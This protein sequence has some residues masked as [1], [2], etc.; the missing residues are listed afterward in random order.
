MNHVLLTVTTLVVILSAAAGCKAPYTMT[1]PTQFKRFMD[2]DDFKMI[3]ADGVMLRARQVENYPKGDL[4]FWTDAMTQHLEA[5]GYVLREKRC[6]KNR[7]HKDAC[8][9]DFLLP[10][11]AEDWAFSETIFVVD[12][13][14]VLVEAAG[15]FDRYAKIETDL[16]KALETFEP[17][18]N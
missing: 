16:A 6:F 10:H 9:L 17:N 2:T 5:S 14:L 12:D 8:T 13:N 11:G 7:S 1:A 15:P 4:S 18:L 3:T